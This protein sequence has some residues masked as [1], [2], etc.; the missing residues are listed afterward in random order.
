M[1]VYHNA[2]SVENIYFRTKYELVSD[3][4]VL[5]NFRW[6]LLKHKS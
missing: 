5:G 3:I 2:V 6:A 4:L 1:C